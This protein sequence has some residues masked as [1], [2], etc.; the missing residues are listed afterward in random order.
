MTNLMKLASDLRY[1]NQGAVL[2]Q[3]SENERILNGGTPIDE[4][5][6][7]ERAQ[8]VKPLSR[9]T[10]PFF[11]ENNDGTVTLVSNDNY[12][13]NGDGTITL[14]SGYTDNGDGTVTLVV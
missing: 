5:T 4:D 8:T 2:T 12:T 10:Q 13:D 14:N 3:S 11:I 7:N 1:V 6:E 9:I